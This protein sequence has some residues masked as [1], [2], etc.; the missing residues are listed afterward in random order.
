MCLHIKT[1]QLY[2]EEG[3]TLVILIFNILT[4]DTLVSPWSYV[5]CINNTYSGYWAAGKELPKYFYLII[6][7]SRKELL[8]AIDE[9]QYLSNLENGE[10]PDF[11]SSDEEQE[12]MGGAPRRR[13]MMGRGLVSSPAAF[14]YGGMYSPVAGSMV[15]GCMMPGGRRRRRVGGKGVKGMRKGIRKRPRAGL[16]IG[17]LATQANKLAET[18][19][20]KRSEY[21]FEPKGQRVQD[22]ITIIN[23]LVR[24]GT[25]PANV[26]VYLVD[27]ITH[28]QRLGEAYGH[29]LR[30]RRRRAAPDFV[31][32]GPGSGGRRR[33][34]RM[35]Y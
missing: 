2:N 28:A 29:N 21:K 33:R 31:L 35:M 1:Y 11:D 17:A 8:N 10:N 27:K 9:I 23:G 22:K 20:P 14:G 7:M 26:G 5:L 25:V 12:M 13:R 30:P 4:Y 3:V 15:A 19:L 6:N 34:R 24:D 32:S 16:G 18:Y